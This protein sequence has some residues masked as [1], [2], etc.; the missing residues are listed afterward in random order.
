MPLYAFESVKNPKKKTELFFSMREAP[1]VGEVVVDD[2]V[3][4]KRVFTLPFASVDTQI[5]PNS[6]NDFVE[7]TGKKKGSV[8]DLWDC[9]RELSEK[10]A[11]QNNGVDP[12]KKK[13]FDN[14]AKSRHGREHF[15]AKKERKIEKKDFSISY[16]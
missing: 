8:G 1:K 7:K 14:Y 9:S 2:G 5:N 12:V 11:K 16:E 3:E 15:Q 4:W 10:R 13:H 6:V